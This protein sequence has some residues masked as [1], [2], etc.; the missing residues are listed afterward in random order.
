MGYDFTQYIITRM[1]RM[2]DTIRM[3]LPGMDHAGIATQA[4]VESN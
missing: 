2:K 1:K 4:K 3:Y